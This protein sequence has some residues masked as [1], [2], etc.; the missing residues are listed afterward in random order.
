M[1]FK[2]GDFVI[3]KQDMSRPLLVRATEFNGR[4]SKGITEKSVVLGRHETL[5]FSAKKDV[6]AN[7]GNRPRAGS[8]FGIKVEPFLR[9]IDTNGYGEIKVYCELD[10]PLERRLLRSMFK[11][12]KT[13]K[14][15]GVHGIKVKVEFRNP[16]GKYAGYYRTFSKGDDILTLMPDNMWTSDMCD[17]VVLHELGHAVWF[18]KMGQKRKLRWVKKYHDLVKVREA[19]EKE[20]KQ[21]LSD[22]V[23]IGDIKS[24]VKDI[25]DETKEILRSVYSYIKRVHKINTRHLNDLIL[26]Q[27]DVESMWPTATQ[28]GKPEIYLTE[29][30]TTKPEELFAEAFSYYMTGK[31]LPKDLNHLIE[32][33]IV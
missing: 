5:T 4:D 27:D 19:Y 18:Q 14:K 3:V 22:I 17:Y 1:K 24:Y 16:K 25:D 31:K 23:S 13:L 30:A 15:H 11:A 33:S 20:L 7:L 8:Y 9:H 12:K 21:M 2:K 29:Y 10:A 26:N 28:V 6:V 32:K